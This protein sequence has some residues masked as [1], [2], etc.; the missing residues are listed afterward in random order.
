MDAEVQL[1]ACYAS[2]DQ[3]QAD[4]SI[5][6][7]S[8]QLASIDAAT[9]EDAGQLASM[10]TTYANAA[11]YTLSQG[12]PVWDSAATTLSNLHITSSSTT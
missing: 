5:A 1:H 6:A 9:T 7:G 8:T 4:I 10:L 12:G 11:S 3:K 2:V